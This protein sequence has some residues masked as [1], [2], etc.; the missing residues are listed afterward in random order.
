[1]K[2]SGNREGTFSSRST[3]GKC[4][5]RSETP[6]L[7]GATT[8]LARLGCPGV[9]RYNSYSYANWGRQLS[10]LEA[11]GLRFGH[12]R[13]AGAS[14]LRLAKPPGRFAC[15]R[16]VGCSSRTLGGILSHAGIDDCLGRVR[17]LPRSGAEREAPF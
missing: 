7:N 1:M 4:L 5:S 2:S 15:C 17:R 14:D 8:I 10:E 11:A 6:T 16:A 3:R 13:A 12:T 9:S